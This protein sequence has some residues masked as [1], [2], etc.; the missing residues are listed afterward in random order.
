MEDLAPFFLMAFGSGL[1]ALLTPCVFPMIPLTVSF[2]GGHS[3]ISTQKGDG[4]V[5]YLNSSGSG[6]KRKDMS[7]IKKACLYGFF[8]ILIYVVAGTVV[9]YINGPEFANWLSTHWLPNVIFFLI[10]IVFALSFLGMF[11][12]TLPS[13]L[14]NRVD[15]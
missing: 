13:T 1:A 9:A 14:I 5:H 4:Q 6:V 10:F 11:E 12:I 3:S 7:S 8:I 15:G 2:F